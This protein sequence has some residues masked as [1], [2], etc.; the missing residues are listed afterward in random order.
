MAGTHNTLHSPCCLRC[1]PLRRNAAASNRTAALVFALSA[2]RRNTAASSRYTSH[3]SRTDGHT[4]THPGIER[5]YF[6]MQRSWYKSSGCEATHTTAQQSCGTI[7]RAWLGE[8]GRRLTLLHHLFSDT[9]HTT[10][11]PLW[12]SLF[13]AKVAHL[14]CG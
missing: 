12:I 14:G 10:H 9:Q 11:L 1:P 4:L 2:H 8:R 6:C 3:S 5:M 13:A 7:C